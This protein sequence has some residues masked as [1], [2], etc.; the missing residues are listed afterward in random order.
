MVLFFNSYFIDLVKRKVS[1][2]TSVGDL[3]RSG[4]IN[5]SKGYMCY[6]RVKGVG[7][8]IE[9]LKSSELS[10]ILGYSHKVII[11]VPFFLKV[12][13]LKKRTLV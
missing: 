8:K 5:L 11:K 13:V 10:I 3:L 1:Y 2:L 4:I 7:Y 9:Q 12:H 6:V